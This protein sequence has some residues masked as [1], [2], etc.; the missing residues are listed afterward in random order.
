MVTTI[1][2]NE[3]VKKELDRLKEGKETYEQ[4]ILSLMKFK[5][6]QKGKQESLLI[7]S[8]K[9]MAEDMLKINKEWELFDSEIDWEW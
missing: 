4:I 5:E 9:E 6:E 2:L 3:G 1:Q 7:E 8:C